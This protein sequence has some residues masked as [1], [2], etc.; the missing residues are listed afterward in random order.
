MAF[1]LFKANDVSVQFCYGEDGLDV[2]K[3]SFIRCPRSSDKFPPF[4]FLVGNRSVIVSQDDLS[5][6]KQKTDVESAPRL[7]RKVCK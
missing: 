1:A 5:L 4:S 3:T 2:M 6:V 7:N